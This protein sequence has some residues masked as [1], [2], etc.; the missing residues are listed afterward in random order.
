MLGIR[1]KIT[2]E[3]RRLETELEALNI[4]FIK[5]HPRPNLVDALRRESILRSSVYSARIENIPARLDDPL[6]HRKQEVTNLVSAYSHIHSSR[7]P[8]KLSVKLIKKFHALALKQISP[9]A[10]SIRREPWAIFNSAGVAVYLAPA[11][12]KLPDLMSDYVKFVLS[13]SEPGPVVAAIAQFV[14]EKI[15]PFADGN[16]RVGRLISGYLLNNS[17]FSLVGEFEKYLDDHKSEYYRILASNTDCTE[18]IEFILTSL[19]DISGNNLDTIRHVEISAEELKL[20]FRRREILSIIRDHPG[21][22][23]DFIHRRFAQVKSR[24][25]HYDLEQLQKA[26]LVR[27][28]GVSRGVVYVAV[29]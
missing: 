5:Y 7:V 23:F 19:I 22:T 20:S 24:T 12:Y 15:H 2:S 14:F 3:I 8:K 13:L 9:N 11:H 4:I 27:K 21:C 28:L 16:G 17:G 25:L 10:G 6:I 1:W 26:G 29:V 18:F